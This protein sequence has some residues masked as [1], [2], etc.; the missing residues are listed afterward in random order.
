MEA[1]KSCSVQRALWQRGDPKDVAEGLVSALTLYDACSVVC[2]KSDRRPPILT[3]HL[4]L[5]TAF[6]GW[7]AAKVLT[8]SVYDTSQLYPLENFWRSPYLFILQRFVSHDQKLVSLFVHHQSSPQTLG[9]RTILPT[10]YLSPLLP[11]NL[12]FFVKGNI[13]QYIFTCTS[14]GIHIVF[15]PFISVF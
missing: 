11:P 7:R 15:R 9:H 12:F 13:L 10:L 2:S 1:Q 14:L 4:P 6:S 8:G 3:P 5:G